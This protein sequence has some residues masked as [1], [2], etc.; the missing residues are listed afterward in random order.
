M[1][2]NKETFKYDIV[3]LYLQNLIFRKIKHL[4]EMC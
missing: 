1:N 4:I 2:R 3:S